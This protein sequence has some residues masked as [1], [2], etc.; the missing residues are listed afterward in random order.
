MEMLKLYSR[1]PPRLVFK[2]L[3]RFWHSFYSTTS[4]L[5]LLK[6]D[7]S[8][9]STKCSG[10]LSR[11]LFTLAV[12]NMNFTLSFVTF[13]C[14]SA[15]SFPVLFLCSALWS[16]RVHMHNLIFNQNLKSIFWDLFVS[17]AFLSL[18]FFSENF[19]Y[20]TLLEL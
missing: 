2:L 6:D 7:S 5:L 16:F 10:C 18:V 17:V 3:G 8:E 14:Y 4:F 20:F 12:Q 11:S 13:G 1:R 9:V 15:W 19:S